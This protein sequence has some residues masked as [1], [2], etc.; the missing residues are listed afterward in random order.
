MGRPAILLI[1]VNLMD[2]GQQMHI[3]KSGKKGKEKLGE[4][5]EVIGE[6]RGAMWFFLSG[7][8]LAF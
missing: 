8:V 3:Q 5:E 6:S 4:R 2:A 1:C 7:I